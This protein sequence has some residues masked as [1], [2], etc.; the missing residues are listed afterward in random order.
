METKNSDYGRTVIVWRA[1]EY[2]EVERGPQW[3]AIAG[4][5]AVMMI[6]FSIWQSTYAF[7]VVVL[8]LAG[9]YFLTHNHKPKEIEI[10]LTTNGILADGR[11][12]PYTNIESF[13]VI[14]EPDDN[15]K[16]LGLHMKSGMIREIQYELAQQDPTQVRSFLATYIPEQEDRTETFVE[17]VIR[18]LKL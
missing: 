12:F 5:C 3:M 14:F 2:P 8:L 17:K 11:F 7:S 6:I 10:A 16:K 18:I 4:G 1:P 13:W 9:I 15:V